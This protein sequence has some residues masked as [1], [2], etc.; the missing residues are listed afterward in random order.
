M[1]E[2]ESLEVKTSCVLD[3]GVEFHKSVE[4]NSLLVVYPV[5][6]HGGIQAQKHSKEV[7]TKCLRR[8]VK[9][10]QRYKERGTER[11]KIK[12]KIMNK[13]CKKTALKN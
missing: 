12:T 7:K 9:E 5:C 11:K 4:S 8:K 1:L 13:D 3:G 6:S 2:G 10:D